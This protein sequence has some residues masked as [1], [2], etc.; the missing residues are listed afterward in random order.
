MSKPIVGIFTNI[1]M[2]KNYLFPGYLRI[3]INQDYSRSIEEA[4]GVP[5][6]IPTSQYFE[7]LERQI[8]MCD[9]LL[10]SG[11]QDLNPILYNEQPCDKL[12]DLSPMRDNFEFMAYEIANK[13]QKPIFGI[14]RGSQLTNVFHGGSLYQDNS[15]QGTDLKHMNYANPDMPVHDIL[16]NEDSFLFKATGKSKISINSFHHQAIKNL[17]PGFKIAASAP[18]G[19]IEAIEKEDDNQFIAAVQWHPE[20]MSRTNED[21]Q[22]IFKY[23]ISKL[24]K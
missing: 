9:G 24:K 4:G 11:G 14:C 15:L 17:A 3:T 16:I 8:S 21:S 1:E 5:I 20:M 18:D 7:N 10:F 6:L 22:K 19:I 2:D 12:G 13:L 23:F